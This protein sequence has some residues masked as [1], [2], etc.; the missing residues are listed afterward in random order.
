M[1]WGEAMIAVIYKGDLITGFY[2]EPNMQELDEAGMQYDI[3]PEIP[4]IILNTPPG[5]IVKR[6]G[7]GDYVLELLPPPEPSELDI[8]GEQLVQRELETL[9]L[10]SENQ[11]LSQLISDLELRLLSLEGGAGE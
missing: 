4:E 7:P 3:F 9:E 2:V 11:M 6:N 10:R 1:F 8:I 5:N